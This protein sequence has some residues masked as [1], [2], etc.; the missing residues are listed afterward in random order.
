MLSPRALELVALPVPSLYVFHEWRGP[1]L[2]GALCPDWIKWAGTPELL[3]FF[4]FSLLLHV[5]WW[6]TDQQSITV[7]TDGK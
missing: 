7:I 1:P 5:W 6:V 2:Y 3:F 4:F